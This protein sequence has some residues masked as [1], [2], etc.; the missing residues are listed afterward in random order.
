MPS[1]HDEMRRIIRRRV[2]GTGGGRLVLA[3]VRAADAALCCL[4]AAAEGFAEGLRVAEEVRGAGIALPAAVLITKADLPGAGEAVARAGAAFPGLP[5]ATT[6][7]EADR[8]PVADLVWRL[9]DR[10][11]VWPAPGGRRDTAPVVLPRGATVADFVRAVDGRWLDRVR[12]AR[13]SGP[14]A[15][16]PGQP[17]G[18]ADGAADG[19]AL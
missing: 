1:P 18:L 7:Q 15:R 3:C 13:V 4:P 6:S 14:P 8:R 2:Q 17:G 12:R 11:R 16:L 9:L 19:D 10:I 5:L